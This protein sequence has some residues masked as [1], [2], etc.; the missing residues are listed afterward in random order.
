[1]PCHALHNPGRRRLTTLI[2]ALALS[3]GLL[4][5]AGGLGGCATKPPPKP[6]PRF[7]DTVVVKKGDRKLQLI[8]GNA[9]Y[10]EYHIALGANALGHKVQEGD[11]R[12]PEGEYIL[13]WRNPSSTYYKSIHVSYPNTMDSAVARS[14]GVKPGGMIMIHGRPNYI[15][16]PRI[17]LEYDRR[18]WTNGCIAVTDQEMDEIWSLVRDG[19]PIRITP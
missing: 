10:R 13:D 14:L 12:T 1:M 18:D 16:S 15:T 6:A 8:K 3:I 19:T 7:V 11:E 17:Q 9:V 5:L 4:P 2:P